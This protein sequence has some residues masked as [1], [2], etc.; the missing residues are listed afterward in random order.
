MI[1]RLLQVDFYPYGS[2][3]IVVNDTPTSLHLAAIDQ[4][5]LRVIRDGAPNAG[6][7][8]DAPSDCERGDGQCVLGLEGASATLDDLRHRFSNV[9]YCVDTWHRQLADHG[10]SRL[11]YL[12][13]AELGAN[14]PIPQ[15]L[16]IRRPTGYSAVIGRTF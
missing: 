7:V 16:L 3:P 4:R 13:A 6:Q 1:W 11:D 5:I 15:V 10:G 14:S 2:R 12:T 8:L 9:L